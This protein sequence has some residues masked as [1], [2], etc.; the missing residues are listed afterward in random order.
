MLRECNEP[1]PPIPTH[2]EEND[3]PPPADLLAAMMP[4]MN[5]RWL[6]SGNVSTTIT[7]SRGPLN[8]LLYT[9]SAS[10]RPGADVSSGMLPV[11]LPMVKNGRRALMR[12]L[13]EMECIHFHLEAEMAV[14]RPL[15]LA[16]PHRLKIGKPV[17]SILI[18]ERAATAAAIALLVEQV[19]AQPARVLC[20]SIYEDVY[21]ELFRLFLMPGDP[22]L[23]TLQQTAGLM[24]VNVDAIH[25]EPFAGMVLHALR[26]DLYADA[27][28]LFDARELFVRVIDD[29]WKKGAQSL[30]EGGAAPFTENLAHFIL[31][32]LT[33]KLMASAG[34]PEPQRIAANSWLD[35]LHHHRVTTPPMVKHNEAPPSGCRLIR[36]A[37]RNFLQIWPPGGGG[38]RV[39]EIPTFPATVIVWLAL[40][41]N[42]VRLV[43]R[44]LLPLVERFRAGR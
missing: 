8:H 21:N 25:D 37:R 9:E 14:L 20:D 39:A 10:V 4:T 32:Q 38:M 43:P 2:G 33:E 41:Q 17:D 12:G 34:C 36:V 15:D 7:L 40:T 6:A 30:D 13:L 28:T 18:K 35:F 26:R 19:V 42:D 1:P 23:Y 27:T 29:S 16:G 31:L 5:A 3:A 44:Q 11:P 24:R 22:E